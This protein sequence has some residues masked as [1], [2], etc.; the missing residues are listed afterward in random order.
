MRIWDQQHQ[1]GPAADTKWPL[2]KPNWNNQDRQLRGDL[3]LRDAE[4]LPEL[5]AAE[6]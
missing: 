4:A 1:Q 6:I 3:L 5:P 2:Q